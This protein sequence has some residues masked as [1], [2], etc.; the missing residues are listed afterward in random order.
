MRPRSRARR[1]SGWHYRVSL[2][3][4]TK[5][6]ISRLTRCQVIVRGGVGYDNIDHA[7]ARQR[8][9]P[10]C[11]VP[12]YGTEEVADTA[13]GML[14]SLTRGIHRANSHLRARGRMDVCRCRSAGPPARSRVGY[15]R[16]G[17]D[18]H[19]RCAAGQGAGHGCGVL[20]SLQ[21][22]RLRQGFGH[23]PRGNAHGVVWPVTGRHAALS[24]DRGDASLDRCRGDRRDARRFVSGE[25]G[26]VV[27][28]IVPQ[29]RRRWLPDAWPGPASTCWSMSRPCRE[30]RSWPPGAIPSIRPI[31]D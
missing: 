30:I 7:L 12:D 22:G 9:I 20:R 11:N 4:L 28:S 21:T 1:G 2:D 13:V 29:C 31:I 19:R 27:Y 14:L 6:T 8:G 24:A 17:P 16:I 5:M 10:V 15:R 3:P 18:R 25:Y 26:E 23:S